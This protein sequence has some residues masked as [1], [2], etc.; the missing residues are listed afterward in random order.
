MGQSLPEIQYQF[1]S[2]HIQDSSSY[3]GRSHSILTLDTYQNLAPDVYQATHAAKA[4]Q[5]PNNPKVSI[6]C[7]L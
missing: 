1:F 7:C 6:L 4:F 2:S 5:K 3:A